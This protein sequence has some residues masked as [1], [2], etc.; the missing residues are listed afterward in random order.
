MELVYIHYSVVLECQWS[1]VVHVN[2]KMQP[3]HDAQ[4]SESQRT[5]IINLPLYSLCME[6]FSLLGSRH[7]YSIWWQVGQSGQYQ[8]PL[9]HFKNTIHAILD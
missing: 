2:F 6:R 4:V 5:S 7:I 1:P 9:Q 3:A 8:R